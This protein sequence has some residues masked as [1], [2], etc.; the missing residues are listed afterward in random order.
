M[1]KPENVKD[2]H[3]SAC[4]DLYNIIELLSLSSCSVLTFAQHFLVRTTY[5]LVWFGT[6]T[7]RHLCIGVRFVHTI[8]GVWI[9]LKYIIKISTLYITLIFFFFCCM[10]V[11]KW[12]TLI[13]GYMY[14]C[15][16]VR[17]VILTLVLGGG[18]GI[19]SKSSTAQGVDEGGRSRTLTSNN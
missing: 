2:P 5:K 17:C 12:C 9:C 13:R 3:S 14:I 15:T 11:G 18:G 6:G 8:M 1:N 19:N 10:C 16:R 4:S 7:G